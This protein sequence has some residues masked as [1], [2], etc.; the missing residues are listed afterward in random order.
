LCGNAR[1]RAKEAGIGRRDHDED[2]DDRQIA[3]KRQQGKPA[4][5]ALPRGG[6]KGE[7]PGG[8][9][10]Q[11]AT[12]DDQRGDDRARSGA[13]LQ[14]RFVANQKQ[15]K[16]CKCGERTASGDDDGAG[17]AAMAGYDGEGDDQCDRSHQQMQVWKRHIVPPPPHGPARQTDGAG[18]N[19]AGSIAD[20]L[21]LS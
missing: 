14:E 1:R 13:I 7:R 4:P 9:E 15:P 2:A 16:R 3:D 17:G 11:H 12:G 5:A 21:L 18:S 8:N 19:L 20:R 10:E 6:R